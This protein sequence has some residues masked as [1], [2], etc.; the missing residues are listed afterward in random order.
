MQ[1]PPNPWLALYFNPAC[2]TLLPARGKGTAASAPRI[3]SR[4]KTVKFHFMK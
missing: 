4:T 3:T 1:L 2:A